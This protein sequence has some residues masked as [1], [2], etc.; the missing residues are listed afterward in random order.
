MKIVKILTLLSIVLAG[1]LVQII[2][3]PKTAGAGD[4]LDGTIWSYKR[5]GKVLADYVFSKGLYVYTT[6]E[7]D[8]EFPGEYRLKGNTVEMHDTILDTLEEG[9]INRDK[10]TV[11]LIDEKGKKIGDSIVYTKEP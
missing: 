7:F 11:T 10:M 2:S 6:Y 4:I 5:N 9:K 3:P 1:N 8:K